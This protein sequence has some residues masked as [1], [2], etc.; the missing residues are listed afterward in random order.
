[1]TFKPVNRTNSS[2]K[3][4]YPMFHALGSKVNK[5]AI[6]ETQQ[7]NRTGDEHSKTAEVSC[8]IARR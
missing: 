4:N 1:M 6:E 5:N 2:F 3:S 7:R 8:R